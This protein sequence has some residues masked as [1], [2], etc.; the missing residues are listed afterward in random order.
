MRVLVCVALLVSGCALGPQA[1]NVGRTAAPAKPRTCTVTVAPDSKQFCA[2]PKKTC[3]QI[4]TC[5]EAY[6]R[7]TICGDLSLDGRPLGPDVPPST[8][9]PNGVPCEDR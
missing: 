6:Y 4:D 3:Q 7:Y 5:G 2:E 9:Q 1:S 8:G